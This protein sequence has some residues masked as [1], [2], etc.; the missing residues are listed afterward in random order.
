MGERAGFSPPYVPGTQAIVIQT[1]SD[2]KF[3]RYYVN[4][5][6]GSKQVGEWMMRADDV[7]NLTAEQIA[8]KFSLPQVPTHVAEVVV[9][10]GYQMRVTMANDINIYSDRSLGGNGGG[11]G[12]QFELI[13][14]PKDAEVFKTWF[15]NERRLK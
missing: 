6:E 9:P 12:V 8:S 4:N 1:T 3:V 13:T 11:G 7:A 2:I 14:K 5:P 10:A 15:F